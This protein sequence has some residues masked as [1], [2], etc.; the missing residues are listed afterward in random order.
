MRTHRQIVNDVGAAKLADQLDVSI[1]AVRSWVHKRRKGIPGEY[2][3]R[4]V[5][6]RHASFE[7][8]ATAAAKPSSPSK[9]EA[10]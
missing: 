3:A 2:W 10:A 9:Q 1:Y 4:I 7:E 5:A 8:L 6:L